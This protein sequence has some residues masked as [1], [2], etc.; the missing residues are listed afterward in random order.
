[1]IATKAHREALAQR[2]KARGLDTLKAGMHGRYIA[3]DAA[4][5]LAK[6][7]VDGWPDAA[8]FAKLMGDIVTQAQAASEGGNSRVVAFGEMVSLLW[9]QGKREAA[10]YLEQLWNDLAKT[11]SFSLRCAYPIG[12]FGSEADSEPFLKVCAE[13]SSVIPSES[14]TELITDEERLRNIS[15]LAATSASTRDGEGGTE[16]G[17]EVPAAPRVG[18]DRHPRERGRRRAASGSRSDDPVDE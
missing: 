2:L 14:Y 18:V 9:A 16:A 11:H 13:H 17:S 1:V 6:L 3:L 7:S 4:E 15:H 10:I 5:T 8:R 12:S